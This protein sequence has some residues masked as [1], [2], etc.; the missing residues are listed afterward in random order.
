MTSLTGSPDK[1]SVYSLSYTAQRRLKDYPVKN[2]SLP[3]NAKGVGVWRPHYLRTSG[4]GLRVGNRTYSATLFM[5][6]LDTVVLLT[7]RHLPSAEFLRAYRELFGGSLSAGES[8]FELQ[9]LDNRAIKQAYRRRAQ[10]THPDRAHLRSA[11]CLV[12]HTEFQAVVSAY[13]LLKLVREKA[14]RVDALPQGP[15]TASTARQRPPSNPVDVPQPQPAPT[16]TTKFQQTKADRTPS[17][18]PI[19]RGWG[20]RTAES[21]GETDRHAERAAR[22]TAQEQR[23]AQAQRQP[24]PAPEVSDNAKK[25]SGAGQDS[26][27]SPQSDHYFD[28]AIPSRQLPFGQ[29]LYYAGKISWKQLIDALVWQRQQRPPVGQLAKRW[30]MLTDWQV[31][32][33]LESRHASGRYDVKFADYAC[34]MGYLSEANMTALLGRMNM[35]QKP[36]GQYFIEAGVFDARGL[37]QLLT[38]HRRHNWRAV[39]R[40]AR[41]W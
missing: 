16:A 28:R 30:G 11:E 10:A 17:D 35:L 3:V 29:Y 15:Q 27:F 34:E 39:Q 13:E 8:L 21:Q 2:E 23:Q 12:A 26:R 40:R 6:T 36:I 9:R 4:D 41:A 22:T 24:K 37:A 7:N 5:C 38:S 31:E 18:G 33:V 25:P 19:S 20:K 1:G 32:A 14:L